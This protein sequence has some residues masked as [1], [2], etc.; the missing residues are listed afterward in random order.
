MNRSSLFFVFT[1]VSILAFRFPFFYSNQPQLIDGEELVF[2]TTLLS[3]PKIVSKYQLVSAN[4]SGQK[5]T[6]LLPQY[7]RFYYADNLKFSG[8]VTLSEKYQSWSMYYP[9]VEK[10]ESSLFLPLA[11]ASFIR[12][13]ATVL[14]QK[15]LPSDFASLLMGIV[16]GVKGPMSKDFSDALRTSGV[17]HVVAASGMNVVLVAGFLQ[18]LFGN[19]FKRQIGVFLAF[20]GIWFYAL[21][22]GGE[23]SILRATIMASI[24]F[25]AQ[26]LGRQYLGGYILCVTGYSMLLFS[27]PLLF[28]IGFQLSFLATAGLLYISP[29]LQKK[30]R[31]KFLFK[32]ELITTLAAQL[33]T[34]PLLVFYFGNYSLWSILANI[35]VLWTVPLLM[36][37]GTSALIVSLVI[38][39]LG[40]IILFLSLPF[41]YYFEWVVMFFSRLPGSL[42]IEEIPWQFVTTYYFFL[43]AALLY[44]KQKTNES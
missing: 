13:K 34:V 11:V 31:G 10:Q 27:P 2:S 26:I 15:N 28:D 14:Y 39:P 9:R 40:R 16:F 22:A 30:I 33:A 29:F 38:E 17:F 18:A 5:I 35:L 1:L 7:P 24:L 41:L 25:A 44:L 6:I 8:K 42:T 23:A 20:L 43:L 12:Q 36:V 32:D 3:E 21:L 37:I 4:Y 19:L